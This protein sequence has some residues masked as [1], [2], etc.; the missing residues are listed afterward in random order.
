MSEKIPPKMVEE[1]TD[2]AIVFVGK[3]E[4][5]L[6]ILDKDGNEI[7]LEELLK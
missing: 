5:P 6:P 2:E 7:T 1:D 3:R 4:T